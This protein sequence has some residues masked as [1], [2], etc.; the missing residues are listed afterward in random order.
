MHT[1]TYDGNVTLGLWFKSWH[2]GRPG[3]TAHIVYIPA[4]SVHIRPEINKKTKRLM[5]Q[6]SAW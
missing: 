5:V 3:S 4:Q 6:L 2:Q 1:V